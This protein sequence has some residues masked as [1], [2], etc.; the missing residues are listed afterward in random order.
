MHGAGAGAGDEMIGQV[1]AQAKAQLNLDAS[2]QPLF[3]AAVTQSKAAR[4]SLRA[5]H[6]K[7]K[8]ALATELLKPQP[9]LASLVQV[10]DGVQS[11]S[12]KIRNDTRTAWLAV[13][14]GLSTEQKAVIHALVAKRVARAEAFGERM[15]QH[16]LEMHNGVGG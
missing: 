15:R 10:A 2:Q 11:D 8:D 1:I 9:N 12:L 16:F 6:Q 3:D 14:T 7:A 5:L 4:V 13:Y